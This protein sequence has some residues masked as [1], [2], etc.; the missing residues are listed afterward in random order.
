[1]WRENLWPAVRGRH[2]L[3]RS[4]ALSSPATAAFANPLTQSIIITVTS[5]SEEVYCSKFK[6]SSTTSIPVSCRQHF[7][8]VL[9][10]WQL[11]VSPI[12]FYK[13]RQLSQLS[14]C[15]W[16]E[17][18]WFDSWWNVGSGSMDTDSGQGLEKH[19][20]LLRE[21]GPYVAVQQHSPCHYFLADI[22]DPLQL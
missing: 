12:G 10:W 2:P 8:T 21:L 20:D 11:T 16:V 6:Y 13:P 1:M 22:R 18:P 3:K 14:D 17:C 5:I 15:L 19:V 7:I 4:S 9:S